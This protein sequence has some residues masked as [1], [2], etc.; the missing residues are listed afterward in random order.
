MVAGVGCT[1]AIGSKLVHAHFAEAMTHGSKSRIEELMSA[2]SA[3]MQ[4]L[5]DEAME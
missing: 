3:E 1:K 5:K 4:H 2:L